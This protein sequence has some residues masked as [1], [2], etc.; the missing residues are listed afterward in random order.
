[1]SLQ[2]VLIDETESNSKDG[3][4]R[5]HQTI[6]DPQ[7]FSEVVPQNSERGSVDKRGSC[8]K[9]HTIGHIENL[10][11][12]VAHSWQG[13]TQGGKNPPNN[14]CDAETYLVC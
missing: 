5:G 4:A 12:F 14:S 10:Y 6:H 13:H 9:Q 1:M 11:L 7:L 3:A 2:Y 8:T